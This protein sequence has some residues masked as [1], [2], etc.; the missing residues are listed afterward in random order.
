MSEFATLHEIVK[1][2]H[3]NLSPGAWD[4]LTGGADTETSLLRN[5]Q[6]LDSLAFKPM[7]LNDVREIDLAARVHGKKKR[8]PIV[9]APMGSLDALDPGGALS[10]AKAAEE[11][12]VISYLSS[13]TRPGIDEIASGTGHEKVFQLYVRGD[14]EWISQITNK[15]IDLGYIYFCLTVDVAIYSRR[16]RDLIKRYKPSGRARNDEGWEFQA[17]LDWDLVKWF[18]DTWDIPLILKGIATA[19][20]AARAV[21]HGVDVVY[22]SNHGGRQLDHSRGTIDM[23][24]EIVREV[25]GKAEVIIDG[26]FCRGADIVK[27]LARGANAVAIGKIQGLGLAAAGQEGVVRVLELLEVEMNTVMGLLGLDNLEKLTEDFLEPAQPVVAPAV[28]SAFPF[29]NL[30]PQEY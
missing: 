17:A 18:K 22:V 30:L 25:G 26:G 29:L 2:A 27:A 4:Y 14:R 3:R 28:L 16:E 6:A 5:R 12:G 19:E 11:F 7:V 23:L 13:V 8:L 20:D 10:V 21:G 1:A 9:L 15:A 24:P